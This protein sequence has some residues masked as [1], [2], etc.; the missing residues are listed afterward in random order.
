MECPICG[1]TL[2]LSSKVCESCGHEYDGFF[3]T[4]EFDSSSVRRSASPQKAPRQPSALKPSRRPPM[5]RKKIAVIVGVVVLVALIGVALFA[6][7]P[8]GHGAPGTAEEAVLKYYD[9]LRTGDAD[10]LFSLFESGYLPVAADKAGI[11]AALSTNK[12]T[13]SQPVTQVLSRTQNT[14][15][16]AIKNLEVDISSKTK[17]TTEKKSLAQYIQSQPGSNPQMVSVVKLDNTGDGWH[18][19]GRP[20]GGWTPDSIWLIGEIRNP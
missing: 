12:Y 7:V 14:A 16:V 8:R 18:I 3:L 19:S 15:L 13:V 10:G 5:D 2:P 6:F 17:G 20:I 11:K 4:E 9:Y 1:E